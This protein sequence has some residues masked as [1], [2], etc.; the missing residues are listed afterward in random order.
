MLDNTKSPPLTRL[1]RLTQQAIQ[2]SRIINK[3]ILYGYGITV[4]TSKRTPIQRPAIAATNNTPAITSESNEAFLTR[5]ENQ[6]KKQLGT[7][8]LVKEYCR[9]IARTLLETAESI[10]EP[11]YTTIDI[12]LRAEFELVGLGRY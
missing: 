6:T 1:D 3:I 9:L 12:R 7:Y 2:R 4:L 8:V 5:L 10:N 11:I